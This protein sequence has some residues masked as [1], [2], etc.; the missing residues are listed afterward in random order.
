MMKLKFLRYLPAMKSWKVYSAIA[1]AVLLS[2]GLLLLENRGLKYKL[3]EAKLELMTAEKAISD[4][5]REAADY[6]ENVRTE[7]EAE[8]KAREAAEKPVLDD[9]GV[10]VVTRW[11]RSPAPNCDVLP[12]DAQRR[13][14]AVG[15]I[16]DPRVRAE[17]ERLRD[18][19]ERLRASLADL[20]Q[21]YAEAIAHDLKLG[22]EALRLLNMC[23][24]YGLRI[25]RGG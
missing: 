17:A 15:D 23:R 11:M 14:A 16:P 9:I 4:A 18:E 6:A 21:Q 3:S 22:A 10:R 13:D 12:A 25:Q 2:F 1:A 19:V 5:K 8:R 20:N 7:L 24:E